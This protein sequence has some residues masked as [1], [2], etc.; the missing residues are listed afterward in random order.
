MWPEELSDSLYSFT[1]DNLYHS[2]YTDCFQYLFT[3]SLPSWLCR[4]SVSWCCRLGSP[5]G[6]CLGGVRSAKGLSRTNTHAQRELQDWAEGTEYCTHLTK[7]LPVLQ[8]I[9][10]QKLPI[11]GVSV[12]QNWPCPLYCYV[13]QSLAGNNLKKKKAQ[14]KH[15]LALKAEADPQI[16]DS[17]RL[18]PSHNPGNGTSSLVMLY[19]HFG[20]TL[21]RTSLNW[22]TYSPCTIKYRLLSVCTSL[23][24]TASYAVSVCYCLNIPASTSWCGQ[25][26]V[27]EEKPTICM[28]QDGSTS[29]IWLSSTWN[30]ASITEE[31]NFKLYFIL[32]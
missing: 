9:P 13:A 2:Y 6:K 18:S 12:G 8:E 4:T 28:A 27:W 32:I 17:W 5:A 10:E 29:S 20:H 3:E 26:W 30:V 31:V 23:F 16:A 14:E 22:L 11:W 7:P 25:L 15:A 24:T 21:V 1:V 19:L